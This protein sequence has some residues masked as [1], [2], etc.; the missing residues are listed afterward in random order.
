[1]S[2]LNFET[3][4]S[5]AKSIAKQYGTS[6]K[7][8]HIQLRYLF[9]QDLVQS[10][11]LNITQI[12]GESNPSDMLTKFPTSD[13]LQRHL[14]RVGIVASSGMSTSRP[15]DSADQPMLCAPLIRS[16]LLINPLRGLF[17]TFDQGPRRTTACFSALLVNLWLL[18]RLAPMV[19][20]L[21]FGHAGI[22]CALLL[23][24]NGGGGSD[25]GGHRYGLAR[26]LH[27]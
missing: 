16:K 24:L 8:G 21:V 14:Q 3:D 19:W 5:S 6:R 1:M 27:G 18:L 22:I 7:T 10:G 23:L 20:H 2:S 12:P 4:S 17:N 9:M 11:I 26:L 25:A 13:M 15:A